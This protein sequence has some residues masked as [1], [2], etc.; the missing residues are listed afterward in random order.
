MTSSSKNKIYNA[1]DFERYH[2]GKMTPAE[3][4]A[5]EKAAMEDPFL[6]D[7]LQGY[8]LIAQPIQ[9]LEL[10][11]QRLKEQTSSK[12][13]VPF[14]F[15]NYNWL[16]VAAVFVLIAGA[17]WL[18]LRMAEN[19]NEIAKDETERKLIPQNQQ[20]TIIPV[21]SSITANKPVQKSDETAVDQ[22][23]NNIK[24][25][26]GN[27]SIE[28][29]V[30]AGNSLK[31][32]ENPEKNNPPT[33]Q[34]YYTAPAN[35]QAVASRK[36][37]INQSP[38]GN[39]QPTFNNSQASPSNASNNT[40]L[41]NQEVSFNAPRRNDSLS[42]VVASL[43][44]KQVDTVKNLNIVL[45]PVNEGLSEVVV[46]SPGKKENKQSRVPQVI[47]DTLEP[48]VGWVKFD[49][50][51]AN[52]LNYPEEIKTKQTLP[53]EV[54]LSFDINKDGEPINIAVTKSLC[55]KCDEEAIRLLKEGP[56]WKKK[57]NK[58][59]KVTIRF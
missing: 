22:T 6:A 29:A 14:I 32:E 31:Q 44:K 11:K 25:E 51:I 15:R 38:S 4:H 18:V 27:P 10:I 16:K 33:D 58:K 24:K 55:E 45:Q 59:G 36:A 13:A 1:A 21:D 54:E 9:D 47:V 52:N 48:T 39:H 56:R 57:K 28:T 50:Y 41:R 7:A 19:H 49:E 20:S 30:A 17:G 3:M 35:N 53:G 5:L 40:N 2:A 34:F 26:P 43:D 12:K 46:I 42:E 8:S 23:E 37:V